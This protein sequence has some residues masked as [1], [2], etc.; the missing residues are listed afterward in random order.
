MAKRKRLT[1]APGLTA[2]TETVTPALETKSAFPSYP[3]GVAPKPAA[4][5][6]IAQVAGDAAAQSALDALADEMR[7]ARTQGRLVQSLPLEAISE[8][9]MVRDRMVS[10]P[11]EM[12]SLKASLQARGQQT[13]IEVVEL[14]QGSYGL[15]SGWRRLHA[16]RELLEETNGP[17]FAVIEA[18]IKP[19]DTVSD[20]YVAMVEE[21]EIRTNLSFYERAHLA[22][23]AVRLGVYPTPA[24]A[25]QTLFANAPSAKRSKIGSFVRLHEALGDVLRFPTAIPERLGLALVA[26]TEAE[27]GFAARLKG[28]LRKTPPESAEAERAALE[29]ALR[30]TPAKPSPPEVVPG[31]QLEARKGRLVLTGQGVTEDLRR[32]LEA[33][34]AQR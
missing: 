1:P 7:V 12:A 5:A 19:I 33:W 22:C 16:L 25:I 6:P 21:N 13:P 28:A 18:L 32:D 8:R 30:K 31:V 3:M 14:G 10:D 9:H 29:R 11:Q 20:G 34:L 2:P 17:R 15:I 26:A 23:E 4:R 24:R 27:S